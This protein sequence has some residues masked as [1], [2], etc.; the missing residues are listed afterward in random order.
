[1]SFLA[2]KGHV[3]TAC[4]KNF[5][6]FYIQKLTLYKLCKIDVHGLD[7]NL[8]PHRIHQTPYST[9]FHIHSVIGLKS[10]ISNK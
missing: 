10:D 6:Q 8:G 7:A 2:D 5:V 9:M 4:F 1:M 3:Y